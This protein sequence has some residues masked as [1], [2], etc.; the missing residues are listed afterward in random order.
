MKGSDIFRGQLVVRSDSRIRN[1]R[2]ANLEE[3][4]MAGNVL[5]ALASASEAG[6]PIWIRRGTS[7]G[8]VR[9]GDDV[10]SQE[11]PWARADGLAGRYTSV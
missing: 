2:I 6:T 7:V 8:Q 11:C 3:D 5:A 10:A 4:V 9:G 1:G